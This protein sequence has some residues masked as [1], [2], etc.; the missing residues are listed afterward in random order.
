MTHEGL[1]QIFEKLAHVGT[2]GRE[3]A[4]AERDVGIFFQFGDKLARGEQRIADEV[5]GF[6]FDAQGALET[7]DQPRRRHRRPGPAGPPRPGLP[8]ISGDHGIVLSSPGDAVGMIDG[9]PAS[10]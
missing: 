5:E 3:Y 8:R 6:A 2:G 9:S 4:F 10:R 1:D 7:G